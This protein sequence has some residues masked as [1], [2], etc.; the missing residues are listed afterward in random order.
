MFAAGKHVQESLVC[1]SPVGRPQ[2]HGLASP[3][4]L[5]RLAL[6]ASKPSIHLV[7]VEHLQRRGTP[8]ERFMGFIL[9]AAH[10]MANLEV[11]A[12]C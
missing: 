3:G 7:G 11:V 6:G 10:A 1:S 4:K 8:L 2:H 9:A 12:S 5:S